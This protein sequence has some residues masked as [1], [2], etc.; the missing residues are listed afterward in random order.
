M[1][2][3][4]NY[5]FTASLACCVF[6]AC[7]SQDSVTGSDGKEAEIREMA[8]RMLDDER[9]LEED[10]TTI[11]KMAT[12]KMDASCLLL[13]GIYY[14][15]PYFNAEGHPF[16]N[17]GGFHTGSIVYRNRRYEGIRMKY[18]IFHQQIVINP[19]PEEPL[20]MILL[21]NEFISEFWLEG[22]HFRKDPDGGPGGSYLQVVWEEEQVRCYSSWYKLRY[23]SYRDGNLVSYRFTDHKQKRY[24]QVNGKIS[25]YTGNRSFTGQFPDAVKDQVKEFLRS[26]SIRVNVADAETMKE[27]IRFSQG[28]LTRNNL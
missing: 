9:Q 15:N 27:V 19:R 10:F 18:D 12:E 2:S 6:T 25:G 8:K 23:K 26:K 3:V 11:Y 16:L 1:V 13:N 5:F 24:L 17:D 4:F 14:E 21:S 28:V 22:L 7:L 20:L